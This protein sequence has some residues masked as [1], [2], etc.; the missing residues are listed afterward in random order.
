MSATMAEAT[1]T[2]ETVLKE[3][4]AERAALEARR[5]S[6]Q[7]ALEALRGSIIRP[8]TETR[9]R[10]KLD[11]KEVK[12][13]DN[14]LNSVLELV[15]TQKDGMRQADIGASLDLNSGMVSLTLR[16]LELAG[17]VKR[18]TGKQAKLRGSQVWIPTKPKRVTNV[19]PG[20]GIE[21]GRIAS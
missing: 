17:D 14:H 11:I 18:A 3:L 9:E 16:K 21:E 12:V 15:R 4:D 1:K 7:Q 5:L 19:S 8:M 2:L 20:E 13:P 6:V 10:Q